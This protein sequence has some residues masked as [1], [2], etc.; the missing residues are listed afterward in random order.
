MHIRIP[1]RAGA[2]ATLSFRCQEGAYLLSATISGQRPHFVVPGSD[3]H[4][5]P[6]CGGVIVLPPIL[7][8]VGSP[9]VNA[10]WEATYRLEY[11]QLMLVAT[12]P[13]LRLAIPPW[14]APG[15][16]LL[17]HPGVRRC[18]L[19]AARGALGIRATGLPEQI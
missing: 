3:L 17:D 5:Y 10:G 9:S 16:V 15:G 8:E 1:I 4:F 19:L 7:P 6:E 14:T 13:I 11:Q 18:L 2:E 12:Y